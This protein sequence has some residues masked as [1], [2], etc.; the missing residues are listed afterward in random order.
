MHNNRRCRPVFDSV[1][2]SSSD[3]NGRD[4]FDTSDSGNDPDYQLP[5]KTKT[6]PSNG[7]KQLL[8]L[9]KKK[10]TAQQR[11]S[12]LNNKFHPKSGAISIQ[13]DSTTHSSNQ[14]DRVKPTTGIDD[15][16]N[17]KITPIELNQTKAEEI[18]LIDLLG[19][20]TIFSSVTIL[21]MV[22]MMSKVNPSSL[23]VH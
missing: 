7:L 14:I 17:K 21:K 18:E 15:S 5:K 3:E 10:L 19:S 13:N 12:R 4:P 23:E 9:Q 11:I 20:M 22:V 8:I 1:D 16:S 2:K 6:E